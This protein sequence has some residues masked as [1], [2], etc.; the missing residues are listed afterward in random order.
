MFNSNM[1]KTVSKAVG[2]GM[3]S[4]ILYKTIRYLEQSLDKSYRVIDD[5]IPD[6]L[7]SCGGRYAGYQ[8]G[9]CHYIKNNF[10]LTHKKILGISAG[11]WNAVFMSV[12]NNDHANI[13]LHKVFEIKKD[14]L[15]TALKKT[16]DAID[17][18][19]LNNYNIH[20]IYIGTTYFNK[21]IIYNKFLSIDQVSKCCVASSFIPFLTHNELFYFYNNRLSFDGG[22]H[23]D[24]YIKKIP[25]STL[26]ID[27]KM[28]GR[29]LDDII[30]KDIF[31]KNK[32]TT[33]ELYIKGYHDAKKNHSYF[34]KYLKS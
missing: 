32:P 20:N 19:D 29:H 21:T 34:D 7:I 18:Y 1:F 23:V 9:I 14:T 25:K 12:K 13:I 17:T 2:I 22:F 16:K 24:K 26:V 4:C 5:I 33:Y 27:F 15:P 30:Y 6:I 11:A 28:F 10:D 3:V 8:L 31:R